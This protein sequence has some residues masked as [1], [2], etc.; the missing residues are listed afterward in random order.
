MISKW[1]LCGFLS[2]NL[3]LLSFAQQGKVKWYH[4]ETSVTGDFIKNMMGGINTDFTYI[5]M[6][7]I[8]LTLNLEDAGLWKGAEIFLHGLN[9]HGITPSSDIVGDLQVSSNIESGNYTGFY[10]YYLQQQLGKFCFIL[11]QH[12]LNSEF[13]GTEYGG[14]FVNSSFG[15]APSM[16]LNVPVSIYPMAAPAFIIKYEKENR[17]IAKLGIYDGDPGDPESNR[18][19]LQP[20]ISLDEG[21]LA[22]AEYEICHTMNE[23]PVSFKLGTYYHTNEFIDYTDT[24]HS[25]AGNYGLY[26][27]SDNV[28]WSGF[29]HP[30]TYLGWFIQGGWA[31]GHI[32]Q[33]DY[34]IGSGLHLNGILPNR[35]HDALGVAFAYAN[36]SRHVRNLNPN[37]L[38]GEMA[39]EFTYK[40]HI[41]EHYYIQ[42][43]LQYIINPGANAELNDALVAS[44]RFNI[45]LEN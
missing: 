35:Y 33:V 41:F 8:G 25:V 43:N 37:I 27:V 6:E 7:E 22:I 17:H 36:I 42:P 28:L 45:Y 5:G 31:P 13:V 39:I 12:D 29:N 15:I 44:L 21:L 16:S 3:F 30:H 9:T 11:G 40:I 38:T 32:N 14:T 1:F 34:Y 23:L 10:Q 26:L 18:Y 4:L 19:N 20:N 24:S 2:C